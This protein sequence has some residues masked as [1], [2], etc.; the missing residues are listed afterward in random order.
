MCENTNSEINVW[1]FQRLPLFSYQANYI[2]FSLP[3]RDV[4][5]TGLMVNHDKNPNA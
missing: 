1:T 4:A 2:F 3:L 5:I